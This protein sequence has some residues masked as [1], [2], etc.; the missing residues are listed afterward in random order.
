MSGNTHVRYEAQAELLVR[1]TNKEFP[2]DLEKLC[3]FTYS[4]DILKKSIEYLSSMQR[5]QGLLLQTLLEISKEKPNEVPFTV[6]E[7]RDIDLNPHPT[8]TIIQTPQRDDS[9]LL[10]DFDRR[11]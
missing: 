3:N 5:D 1:N 7:T 9:M 8:Q 4:F 10:K 6:I 11:I 2:F